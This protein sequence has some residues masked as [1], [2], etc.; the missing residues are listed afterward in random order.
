MPDGRDVHTTAR[1]KGLVL[2]TMTTT[3][4]LGV[5]GVDADDGVELGLGLFLFGYKET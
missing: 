2:T 4:S 3:L 1:A 5:C